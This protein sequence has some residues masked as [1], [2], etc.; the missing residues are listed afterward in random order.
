MIRELRKPV[1][2]Y[3]LWPSATL[4]MGFVYGDAQA[5]Q[6][7]TFEVASV[8]GHPN[9]PTLFMVFNRPGLKLEAQ[10]APIEMHTIEHVEEPTE[11]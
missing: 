4:A 3:H 6:Q 1:C 10:K 5:E 7:L 8:E 11:N 2:A 9:R